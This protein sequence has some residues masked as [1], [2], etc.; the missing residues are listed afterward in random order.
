MQ[1]QRIVVLIVEYRLLRM[2]ALNF[3]AV[4]LECFRCGELSD[5]GSVS[6]GQSCG[7]DLMVADGIRIREENRLGGEC[8]QQ[9]LQAAGM[10][11]MPVGQED[12]IQ[13]LN[14]LDPQEP[15]DLWIIL[16]FTGINQEVV[17]CRCCQQKSIAFSDGDKS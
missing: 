7:V 4:Y 14:S 11:L 10:I 1:H 6:I 3:Q 16:R 2:P 13:V 9:R 15:C 17:L 8:L 5:L 12:A